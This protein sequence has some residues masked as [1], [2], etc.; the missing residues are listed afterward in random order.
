MEI[1]Y[2]CFLMSLR[3]D[4][5]FSMKVSLSHRGHLTKSADIFG[6]HDWEEDAARTWWVGARDG[7]QHPRLPR[8]SPQ[9]ENYPAPNVRSI[10]NRKP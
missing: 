4:Q 1:F 5:W 10:K 9:T 8:A 7:T 3:L 2:F 6:H